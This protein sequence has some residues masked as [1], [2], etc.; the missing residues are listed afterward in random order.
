[1]HPTILNHLFS[2]SQ[3]SQEDLES[4]QLDQSP[5]QIITPTLL[6]KY[7]QDVKQKANELHQY[8]FSIASSSSAV[9]LQGDSMINSSIAAAVGAPSTSH[10][11]LSRPP[12]PSVSSAIS[13]P[14]ST[15]DLP[16][17][18]AVKL[19]LRHKNT[20]LREISTPS[21]SS[22]SP[23][24]IAAAAIMTLPTRDHAHDP[25]QINPPS[26]FHPIIQTLREQE[27][28]RHV[29]V[30]A[31]PMTVGLFSVYN[32]VNAAFASRL[33]AIALSIGFACIFNGILLRRTCHQ[34][35]NVMELLGISFVLLA[36]FG[37][38][39]LVLPDNLTWIPSLCWVSSLILFVVAL[40][41]RRSGTST[42]HREHPSIQVVDMDHLTSPAPLTMVS[43]LGHGVGSACEGSLDHE[44]SSQEK[45][46]FERSIKKVKV[47]Q[48]EQ[49]TMAIE[50]SAQSVNLGEQEGL[51]PPREEQR[52]T[53]SYKEKLA[54][55]SDTPMVDRTQGMEDLYEDSESDEEEDEDDECPVIRLS[56]AD[57]R[58]IRRPWLRTLFIKVLGKH[59]GYRFLYK[60]MMN[61]WKLQGQVMM[62]DMGNGFYLLRF[63]V[64]ADY[65]RVL[66]D[67][68]WMVGDHV[69]AVRRWQ[70]HF[71]PDTAKIDKVATWIQIPK[72]ELEYYD[73][74]NLIRIANRI[75]RV[76][77]I[78]RATLNT[79]RCNFARICVEVDLTQ[80]LKSKFKL[81]RRVWKIVYEGLRNIC[82]ECGRYGHGREQC[83]RARAPEIPEENLQCTE[84][85]E[86]VVTR[87]EVVEPFGPWM[88]AQRR[89]RKKAKGGVA[90]VQQ[91]EHGL[92]TQASTP[93]SGG[94]GTHNEVLVHGQVVGMPSRFDVL[95]NGAMEE[96]VLVS[97]VLVDAEMEENRRI[98]MQS[99]QS[100]LAKPLEG[101]KSEAVQG[102]QRAKSGTHP[103][104]V[105]TISSVVERER[106]SK[107]LPKEQEPRQPLGGGRHVFTHRSSFE[108]GS[109]LCLALPSTVVSCPQYYQSPGVVGRIGDQG[110]LSEPHDPGDPILNQCSMEVEVERLPK[111]GKRVDVAGDSVM[112]MEPMSGKGSDV[113]PGVPGGVS[114]C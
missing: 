107:A 77:K 66:F 58:R 67:G 11:P 31:V 2:Q 91:K 92:K 71:C 5:E 28:G 3:N 20:N 74:E 86:E 25:N 12:H 37:F 87:P 69:V 109:S 85:V 50:N 78:D 19:L 88:I 98:P 95:A 64:D 51:F 34:S 45:D 68:P 41:F 102:N 26:A 62:A 83:P 99:P 15:E 96:E 35:S 16:T 104:V 49:P 94:T 36:F 105:Q 39:S 17:N 53:S 38:I 55:L 13:L 90:N 52:R 89:G 46:Q 47:T 44:K 110:P 56:A 6:P 29:L 100:E 33:T 10:P 76:L 65:D 24:N 72:L 111:A 8:S 22:A 40:C 27:L 84:V 112:L 81:R 23:D 114:S 48:W 97:G 60:T 54:G 75:G 108:Q 43:F 70:P 59:V 21:F 73:K 103:L 32:P 113:G 63:T 82:Y 101:R 42:H 80:P 7:I 18:K 79:S 57:K 1:M 30:L 93:K 9:P 61:Q 14:S 4:S 106:S